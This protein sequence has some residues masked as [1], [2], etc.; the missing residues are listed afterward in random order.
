MKLWGRLIYCSIVCLSF[1]GFLNATQFGKY[2]DNKIT[3]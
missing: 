2:H 1:I 3:H